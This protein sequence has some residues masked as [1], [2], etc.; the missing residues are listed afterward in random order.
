MAVEME[1]PPSGG[2]GGFSKK[3]LLIGALVIGGGIGAIM[4]ISR[5]GAGGDETSEQSAPKAGALDIAYQNL[6]EQLL[7]LRGDFSVA[8]AD[9][10]GGLQDLLS[11]LVSESAE[12]ARN[13][14]TLRGQLDYTINNVTATADR[15]DFIG[16]L[17]QLETQAQQALTLGIDPTRVW[18]QFSETRAWLSDYY[19]TPITE[20][21]QERFAGGPQGRL[22]RFRQTY[23]RSGPPPGAGGFSLRDAVEAASLAGND[24]GWGDGFEGLRRVSSGPVYRLPRSG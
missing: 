1:D 12:R 20:R 24:G 14:A 15:Q 11:R 17:N 7:G 23:Q 16:Y 18:Q 19:N 9:L 10:A 22:E 3:Q 4:L 21:T 6:A 8:N 2:I 5:M 13:D